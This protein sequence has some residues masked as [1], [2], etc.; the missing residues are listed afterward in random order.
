MHTEQTSMGEAIVWALVA[1]VSMG[2]LFLFMTFWRSNYLKCVD[3]ESRFWK[4]LGLDQTFASTSRFE[5]SRAFTICVGALTVIAFALLVTAVALHFYFRG[6]LEKKSSKPPNV[7][8]SG[9]HAASKLLVV[10]RTRKDASTPL[11]L[12]ASA[13]RKED[14]VNDRSLA[15]FLP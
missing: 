8:L 15:L 3:A 12:G 6:Q 7:A 4:R 1:F 2:S 14:C 5:R 13:W 9:A 11:P 10:E